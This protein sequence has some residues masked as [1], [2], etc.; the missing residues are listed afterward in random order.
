MVNIV[1]DWNMMEEYAEYCRIGQYQTTTTLQGKELRIL[2][3]RFGYVHTFVKDDDPLLDH[4]L[5]F[6]KLNSFI[7]IVDTIPDEQFFKASIQE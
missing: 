1:R 5:K 3:G 4:I 6:C 2:I 7:E